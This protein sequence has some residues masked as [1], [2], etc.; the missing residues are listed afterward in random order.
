MCVCVCAVRRRTARILYGDWSEGPL[1]RRA[2]VPT[3]SSNPAGI[4]RKLGT[5]I[6]G[7]NL[8]SWNLGTR[9]GRRVAEWPQGGCRSWAE[10]EDRQTVCGIDSLA[11]LGLDVLFWE[12]DRDSKSVRVCACMCTDVF[13]CAAVSLWMYLQQLELCAWPGLAV[14]TSPFA[15][16]PPVVSVKKRRR[17]LGGQKT[18]RSSRTRSR[19]TKHTSRTGD[20]D[21]QAGPR[22]LNPEVPLTDPRRSKMI[23]TKLLQT[24]PD[25]SS[26]VLQCPLFPIV[27]PLRP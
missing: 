22:T 1:P 24:A 25:C 4:R 7:P 3:V 20:R 11:A 8:G 6:R 15:S 21:R 18:D 16:W 27:A 10:L 26:H 19:T 23:P 17:R 9:Q 2:F 5:T 14:G 13:V 12:N